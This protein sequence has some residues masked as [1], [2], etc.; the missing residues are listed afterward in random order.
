MRP[1]LLLLSIFVLSC[2]SS[3][4]QFSRPVNDAFLITRM[5]EKFHFQPK[6]VNDSFSSNIYRKLLKELDGNRIFFTADDIKA[7]SAFQFSIDDEIKNK[8]SA[9][10]SLLTKIY[11]DRISKADTMI[12]SICK[13][14]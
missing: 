3:N 13:T 7:L 10:L 12:S 2:I 14:P 9:F 11:N 8:R 5:A 4:A 6:P 1:V